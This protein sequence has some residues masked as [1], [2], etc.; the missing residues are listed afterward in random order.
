MNE[1]Q[2]TSPGQRP[3]LSLFLD[4]SEQ[5][6]LLVGGGVI[7]AR[8]LERLLAANARITLVAPQ[9]APATAALIGDG[10]IVFHQRPYQASD[11][12]GHKLV[13][14]ATDDAAVNQAIAQAAGALAIP[15][16]VAT[17]GGLSTALLPHTIERGPVRI[18]V[19][20]GGASPA[21]MRQLNRHLE[22]LIPKA[23]G[24]LASLLA[25]C[26]EKIVRR[27]PDMAMR[28]CFHRV[29]VEGEVSELAF[30]G[31]ADHARAALEKALAAEQDPVQSGEVY[32]VG[33]G[34]GDPQLLTLRALRLMQ[35]ADVVIYDRLIGPEI[36]ELIRPDAERIYV[37]K[38]RDKHT[39]P[40]QEINQLLLEHA[41][42]GKRVLRLKGG[43]PF[44][45]GRGGE[46]MEALIAAGIPFQ[47]VPGVTAATGC[48]AYAGIP[49]THRDIAHA[50][51]FLT[52]HFSSNE[53]HVHWP[54]LAQPG[55]TLVFY[56]G[57]FNLGKISERLLEHGMPPG[58]PVAIVQNGTLP[59][60][61]VLVTTLGE[62]TS[63]AIDHHEPGLV[64]VG[65]TVRL[66]SQHQKVHS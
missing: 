43:D 25:S 40:Q 58:V 11:L 13:V 50:C 56:M 36:I 20:S 61:R 19:S 62:L 57:V 18:A 8:K 38:A 35:K 49:L 42:A 34:P 64:I 4:F 28:R 22:A 9:L 41:Q 66:S 14:A 53:T 30:A 54:A 63:C 60:Q 39:R 5:P 59:T 10:R 29:I 7:A 44:V 3:W 21:L 33:A 15:V 23:Y 17:P 6:C 45:F 32:L 65:E 2:T 12:D 26:R 1:Q 16:N 31:H 51:V 27:F 47:V 48:A 52:G 55:Q 37:G 24:E 46:E